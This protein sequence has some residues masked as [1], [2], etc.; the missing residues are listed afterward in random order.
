MHGHWVGVGH[1]CHLRRMGVGCPG[2]G[3]FSLSRALA[4]LVGR[5]L[6]G[7]G[8]LSFFQK[9]LVG[10]VGDGTCGTTLGSFGVVC[11][12]ISVMQPLWCERTASWY[13]FVGQLGRLRVAVLVLLCGA[14]WAALV[15]DV[16]CGFV[17]QLLGQLCVRLPVGFVQSALC[18]T[19]WQL[20]GNTLWCALGAL[21]DFAQQF[22]Y[23]FV[24][25]L[26]QLWLP[27]AAWWLY[28]AV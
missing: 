6:G 3:V 2:P 26:E 16:R 8:A 27:W 1:L 15:T 19:S 5:T 4:K 9:P 21:G 17:V 13:L 18:R 25:R 22:W 14:A 12:A 23:F 24:V 20:R 28:F 11:G 10:A 7:V